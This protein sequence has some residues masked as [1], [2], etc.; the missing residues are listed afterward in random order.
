MIETGMATAKQQNRHGER[1]TEQRV[2]A[3]FADGGADELRF[4]AGDGE[5]PVF[6]Q[7]VLRFLQLFAHNFGHGHGVAFRF[8]IERHADGGLVVEVNKTLCFLRHRPDLRHVGKQN[9]RVAAPADNGGGDVV[10]VLELPHRLEDV[11]AIT[12]L[13][14][15][16]GGIDVVGL[17]GLRDG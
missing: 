4:V 17:K 7:N 13:D 8:A 2:V 10:D 1:P 6:R 11:A 9:R 15:P 3:D 5:V 12:F 14:E 16:A